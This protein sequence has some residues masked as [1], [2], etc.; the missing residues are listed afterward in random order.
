MLVAHRKAGDNKAQ[1]YRL[2]RPMGELEQ[3]TDGDEPVTSAT[4]EPRG[5]KYLVF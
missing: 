4:W 3:I 2:A 1:V 5:G